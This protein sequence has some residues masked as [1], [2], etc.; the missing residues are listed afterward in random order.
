MIIKT[1]SHTINVD[2]TLHQ[3]YF[4]INRAKEDY[5]LNNDFDKNEKYSTY[6]LLV[7]INTFYKNLKNKELEDNVIVF[8][9]RNLIFELEAIIEFENS[10]EDYNSMEEFNINN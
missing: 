2:L 4:W 7:K 8:T 5:N 10:F 1:E 9:L 6:N 3:I